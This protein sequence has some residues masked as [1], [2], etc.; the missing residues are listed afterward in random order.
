MA[1]RTA[2]GSRMG[3]G[4]LRLVLAL[5]GLLAGLPP[6]VASP[7]PENPM[8][9]ELDVPLT[10]PWK[11][12]LFAHDLTGDGRMD[13]VITAPGHVAV[14]TAEGAPLWHVRDEIN[15]GQ[16]KRGFPFPGPHASG[17]IA[18]DMDGDGAEELAY[19]LPDG[20][21]VI[22]EGR[23]GQIKRN[24]AFPGALGLAIADFRGTGD[25]D[26]VLQYSQRELR[27]INLETGQSLWHVT[28]WRGLEHG[29]ARVL[30]LDGDGRDEVL[31][32]ILL[33]P[34]GQALR[35]AAREGTKMHSFD[36]LAVGDIL[37]DPGLEVA[38]AEQHGNDET[39]VM[40]ITGPGWWRHHEPGGIW[41]IGECRS[42]EDPDK[43]AVGEFDPDRPGQEVFARSSCG[44]H[45]WVMAG[46]GTV[47]AAWSVRDTAPPGWCHVGDCRADPEASLFQRFADRIRVDLRGGRSPRRGEYGID[48]VRAVYWD[49]TGQQQL[50]VTERH[51][52]GQI[53]LVNALT[54]EF[55][56][57]WPT[58]A[59]R[60]Y[61]ADVTGDAREELI[62]LEAR[63][64]GSALK[65]FWNEEPTDDITHDRLWEDR[66]YRRMRQNWNYYSP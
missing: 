31:G 38:L 42:R 33:D 1:A 26:A 25:R 17:A 51:I 30:D 64:D 29:I 12:G 16:D 58:K 19:L 11:G 48:I 10:S 63:P 20:T 50:F 6:A 52:D 62:V 24:Y 55:L 23:T 44:N 43:L 41:A 46:D 49:G 34:T 59:V 66:A 47:I 14:Y 27:A 21:L 60:T 57:I 8:V 40:G 9:F 18:G 22:R 32:P 4:G 54:G 7:Y 15:L 2:A 45:P 3:S 13:F 37:P 28:D 53:A 56:R 35:S 36:S 65:I 39:I 5:A 61:A